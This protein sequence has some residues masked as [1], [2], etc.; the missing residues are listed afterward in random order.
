MVS[1]F[2]GFDWVPVV[3]PVVATH[4]VPVVVPVVT[5]CVSQSNNHLASRGPR[6]VHKHMH[7]YRR[8]CTSRLLTSL[9][10][11]PAMVTC[12][13]NLSASKW[14]HTEI[15]D[16]LET[17]LAKSFKPQKSTGKGLR[18]A[19]VEGIAK[20]SDHSHLVPLSYLLHC[21]KL[22]AESCGGNYQQEEKT[23]TE[24]RRFS[25]FLSM[26]VFQWLTT[27]PRRNFANFAERVGRAL[28]S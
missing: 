23:P 24:R 6:K 27:C 25:S 21:P 16:G 14:V 13:P 17:Q 4:W 3:V 15:P 12:K 26:S 10:W 11:A 8:L 5:Q 22:Q 19:K 2:N 20:P 7:Q 1:C 9:Y 18:N 28:S